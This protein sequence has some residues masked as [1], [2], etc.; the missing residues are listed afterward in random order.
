V[1]EVVVPG[2]P[3]PKLTASWPVPDGSTGAG[4]LAVK[5]VF[6]RPLDPK[7]PLALAPAAGTTALECLKTPRL[8]ADAKTLVLL[9]RTAAKTR[10]DVS[11]EGPASAAGRPAA[12]TVLKFASTGEVI[13]N[14]S[15]ALKAAGLTDADEPIEAW[16]GAENDAPVMGDAQQHPPS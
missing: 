4:V 15:D 14:A 10:Y 8:L 7:A 2:G 12:P 3:P 6:D 9:C 5:L 1:G 16:T 11:I 13:D